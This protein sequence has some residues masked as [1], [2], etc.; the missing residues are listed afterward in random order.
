MR[1][2]S[3]CS[4]LLCGATRQT[5]AAHHQRASV[6]Q[7]RESPGTARAKRST[8][9]TP[10]K[11]P[12]TATST[13]LLLAEAGLSRTIQRPASPNE[14]RTGRNARHDFHATKGAKRRKSKRAV[15]RG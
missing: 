12:Q 3:V 1:P 10:G 4:D 5:E 2:R 8:P 7:R 6:T 11:A 9:P 13:I 15:T 14:G